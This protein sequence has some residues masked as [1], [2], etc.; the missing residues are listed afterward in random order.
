[1]LRDILR[2]LKLMV[3]RYCWYRPRDFL[4]PSS[5]IGDPPRKTPP[6]PPE[7]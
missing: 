6:D 2:G 5:L 3:L 7:A 1:M 4:L